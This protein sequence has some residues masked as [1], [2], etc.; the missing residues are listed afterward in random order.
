[1]ASPGAGTSGGAA[2]AST[3]NGMTAAEAHAHALHRRGLED[4]SG[5]ARDELASDMDAFLGEGGVF[6][7][8][9]TSKF[10]DG[11]WQEDPQRMVKYRPSILHAY[12]WVPG[13]IWR[14]MKGTVF[15]DGY[16]AFQVISMS[17]WVAFLEAT[18]G[19]WTTDADVQS[20][21]KFFGTPYMGAVVNLCMLITF[22]LGLFVTLVV[23]RWWEVRVQYGMVRAL[24][25]EVSHIIVANM[26]GAKAAR[27]EEERA[28]A[29][30]QNAR[31]RSEMI[32]Y[33]NF[34]HLLLLTDAQSKE[35]AD[36]TDSPLETA[37]KWAR[38]SFARVPVL[39][40]F[41][42]F[43]EVNT[44][45]GDVLGSPTKLM[46]SLRDASVAA[47]KGTAEAFADIGR[48][49]KCVAR[50]PAPCAHAAPRKALETRPAR[51]R[52][53]WLPCRSPARPAP[54]TR[55]P[56]IHAAACRLLGARSCTPW[57]T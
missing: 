23:N 55:P 25:I 47:L 26:R 49:L 34:A 36:F 11:V 22:I 19:Y 6:A 42:R 7:K 57:L 15:A 46:A 32:R 50:A 5:Y 54:H 28:E 21:I 45:L 20:F 13:L 43:E 4:L 27:T 33:L 2:S 31:G 38:R 12:G 14:N 8:A 40:H 9:K 16:L 44:Q 56:V 35:H 51:A 39:R 29:E 53:A 3:T 52:V 41:L 1:M 18:A 24:S 10:F 37:V 48:A 17:L 30:V